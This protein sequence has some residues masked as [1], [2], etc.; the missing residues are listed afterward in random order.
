MLNDQEQMQYFSKELGVD[1]NYLFL[2]CAFYS[3]K[4]KMSRFLVNKKVNLNKIWNLYSA[5][6]SLF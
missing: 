5:Y 3:F 2:V 6:T 1:G 4:E